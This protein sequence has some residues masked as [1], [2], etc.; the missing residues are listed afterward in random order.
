MA[1][2]TLRQTVGYVCQ[3]YHGWRQQYLRGT[4]TMSVFRKCIG[5][6]GSELGCAG[7]KIQLVFRG[8]E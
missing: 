4:N 6:P 3:K 8:L 2:L 1:S 5:S 7:N